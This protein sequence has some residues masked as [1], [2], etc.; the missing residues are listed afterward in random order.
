MCLV[1]AAI[2]D[3]S[4][5]AVREAILRVPVGSYRGSVTMDGLDEPLTIACTLTVHHDTPRIEVDYAGTSP[6][7][8]GSLNCYLN[9]IAAETVF[10]LLT[11]LQPGTHINGGSLRPFRV[12][13]P[14]GCVVNAEPNAAVG[15]RSLVVQFVEAA[16]YNALA[17]VVPDRVLAEPAATVWPILVSG[18]KPHGGRF[19]EM[20]LL[21]GG[22]GARPNGDGVLLGFPAPIVSTKVEVLESEDPFVIE[23]SELV[24]GSG[25]DGRFR[26]GRG[27]SFVLRC[28]VLVRRVETVLEMLVR[29]F[30]AGEPARYAAEVAFR[31][32]T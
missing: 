3:R 25:G 5:Q 17:P 11:V 29:A 22:L 10:A 4:E 14:S 9:Y 26:G 32:R 19:V 2:K 24:A 15:A 12:T 23:H 7:T 16:V 20:I 18:E 30:Q 1:P 8:S 28:V 13:A 27:Q 6:Q 21:N 31:E